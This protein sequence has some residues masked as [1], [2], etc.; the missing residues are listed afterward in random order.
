MSYLSKRGYVLHKNSVTD[1]ELMKIKLELKG[2]PLV[3]SKFNFKNE[4][5][6]YPVYIE[7]KN[8]IYIPKM[9]GIEK[10][11]F[12]ET[13]LE[14]YIGKEW[15]N[16]VEFNGT[17]L[18]RQIK[19]SNALITACEENG[20]GILELQTGFGKC[21]SFN[22]DIL[23]YDGSIKKVQNIQEGELLMGDDSTPRKV[24]SLARGK[25]I[26][27]DIIPTKGEKY[28]VN[29][30][31]ILCLKITGKPSLRKYKQ[32]YQ[33]AWI[34]TWFENNKY[35]TK[36]FKLDNKEEAIKFKDSI[37]QQDIM[38]IAV[39]DYIKLS[40]NIKHILKG[41]K[42]AI[43][44]PIKEIDL[45]PYMIGFWLKNGTSSL[46]EITTQ[47]STVIKYFKQNL[48]QYKCYIQFK[49]DKT[50]NYTYI[51]NGDGTKLSNSNHF[52]NCF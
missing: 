28:T 41:Y 50:N 12:P 1:D 16:P 9:F 2:K 5:P 17:L 23:M 44:F 39:K 52:I 45:D 21:H 13:V 38:E 51:I 35:I 40:K 27:Y 49:D 8:K 48:Q 43:D 34:V 10:Y 20:G 42:T 7:T 33:D 30:E 15:D 37:K 11:G 3:D 22:T 18:E 24:L 6:S 32:K 36:T 25:D 29:Q 4:N 47:D 46:P 19:P 26:M 31:H 14:N